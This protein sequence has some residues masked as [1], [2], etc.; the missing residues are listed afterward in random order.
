MKRVI[1]I[2]LALQ[3]LGALSAFGQKYVVDIVFEP[4]STVCF[5]Y[6]PTGT[7]VNKTE[8]KSRK[9]Y[10]HNGET[11]Q[12]V[13]PALDSMGFVKFMSNRDV[14]IKYNGQEY[15]TKG[16]NLVL[17]EDN[18]AGTVDVAY[19]NL[20]KHP[21]LW[22]IDIHKGSRYLC[23]I[24]LIAIMLAI[25]LVGAL[26]TMRIGR[27]GVPFMLIPLLFFGWYM[28]NFGWEAYWF[29][30]ELAYRNTTSFLLIFA[31]LETFAYYGIKSVWRL[32]D[33]FWDEKQQ[34]Y[35]IERTIGFL[36]IPFFF[37]LLYIAIWGG[38]A[39][40][41]ILFIII[42]FVW[43]SFAPEPPPVECD[44][45]WG[46]LIYGSIESAIDLGGDFVTGIGD[47]VESQQKEYSKRM[48]EEEIRRRQGLL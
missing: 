4:D 16:R 30:D 44:T 37:P 42:A 48:K 10:I 7:K 6:T 33:G 22:N 39:K 17:S 23:N 34:K 28:V 36:L 32:I 35:T 2:L 40:Q 27:F 19:Q 3:Q 25:G 21:G 12:V 14:R 45:W 46:K 9:I 5:L 47:A 38:L 43:G 20:D 1:L 11:V 8:S 41:W 13:S 18:P 26:L 29:M 31:L 24:W 15:R